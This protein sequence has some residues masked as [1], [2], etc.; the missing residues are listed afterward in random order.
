MNYKNEIILPIFTMS[1]V[2]VLVIVNTFDG[3]QYFSPQA[4]G[5]IEIL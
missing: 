1:S 2:F 5:N 3:H 4:T